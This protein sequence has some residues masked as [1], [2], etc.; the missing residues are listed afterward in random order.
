MEGGWVGEG[1]QGVFSQVKALVPQGQV[2][3]LQVA[4]DLVSVSVIV[5]EGRP[6]RELERF[7]DPLCCLLGT[8]PELAD[9]HDSYPSDR[10]FCPLV[11]GEYSHPQLLVAVPSNKSRDI[12]IQLRNFESS[13][14]SNIKVSEQSGI[15]E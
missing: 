3:V 1:D 14:R 12:S 6:R 9:H 7:A 10:R 2:E 11:F 13:K 15:N 5:R 8:L 4:V